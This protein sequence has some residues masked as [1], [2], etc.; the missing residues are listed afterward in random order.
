MTRLGRR[1]SRHGRV[2]YRRGLATVLAGCSLALGCAR[3]TDLRGRIDGLHD[4]LEQVERNGAYDCAPRELALAR[5]HLAFATQE[6]AQGDVAIA[7][8]HVIIAQP[9]V[10]AAFT[11]SPASRC[12][13]RGVAIE[14]P[15]DR[16]GDG[17]LDP[18]DACPDVPEDFDGVDDE[19]GC[20]EDDDL[21]GDGILDS[22]DLCV[23][24]AEDADGQ[25]D[26]D[27]CPDP[28]D[29]FDGVLDGEDRCRIDPEDRDGFQDEDGC[30]DPDNDGDS[31]MDTDDRCPDE[32]GPA[33]EQGC[34]RVYEDVEVTTTHIRIHQKIHFAFNRARIR[35]VSFPI[36]N[37]VTQVLKDYPDIRVEIQ[38]HTDSRGSDSY[39][40]RLS[41]QRARAVLE[42]L[43]SKGIS[44][45]RLTSRGYGESRPLES[46]ST[47]DGRARNRR[48]EFLRTD[49]A[50]T[51]PAGDPEPTDL[52]AR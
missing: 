24:E 17:I 11:L 42:Y 23:A 19:D 8:D 22:V 3:V 51:S 28:D 7:E 30:P 36:L 39:N 5:A 2:T 49:P 12:S 33:D 10:R 50:A 46:N 52:P 32:P 48:V 26:A 37:T 4:I 18:D 31:T 38:G 29:D 25:S 15:G 35:S 9:N 47:D 34:P 44:E 1:S 45:S 21:D 43:V 41:D 16:D 40:E 6:L 13:P 14:Q 27:G 20:P